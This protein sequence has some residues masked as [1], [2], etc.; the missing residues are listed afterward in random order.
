MITPKSDLRNLVTRPF[1]R[2]LGEYTDTLSLATNYNA[3]F[4]RVSCF[5]REKIQWQQLKNTLKLM[6][7][8]ILVVKWC[9]VRKI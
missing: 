1:S 5:Q 6:E 2:G 9:R 3:R 7:L 8:Q 4:R